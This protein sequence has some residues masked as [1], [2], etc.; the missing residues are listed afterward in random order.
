MADKP[1]IIHRDTITGEIVSADYAAANP[2]TTVRETRKAGKWRRRAETAE[3]EL[4]ELRDAINNAVLY[5]R[6]CRDALARQT[7]RLLA[8][9]A[10]LDAVREPHRPSHS[11]ATCV[12]DLHPWPCPTVRI[13]DGTE[14]GE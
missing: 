12:H 11:G 7:P 4:A 1:Q 8:A 3:A 2:A 9:Q 13:I 14:G 10:K 5:E 6:D